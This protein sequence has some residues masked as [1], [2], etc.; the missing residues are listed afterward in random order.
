MLEQRVGLAL[1]P[2]GDV[3][4]GRAAVRRVV[5]EAAVAGRVVRRRDDDAVGRARPAALCVRMAC[6]I[7]GVGVAPP[8]GVD[9][10]VDAVARRGPRRSSPRGL[11]ERVR[12]AAEEQRPVDALLGAVAADRVADRDDVGL[13]ERAVERGA[14]MARRAE[15]DGRA[16]RAAGRPRAA[17]RR[18]RGRP[19][20]AAARRAGGCSRANSTAW[21]R[22]RDVRPDERILVAGEAL[23]DLVPRGRRHAL[24]VPRRRPLH[25]R[26]GARPPRPSRGL[27]RPAEHRPL[28]G[29]DGGDARRRRRGAGRRGADGRPDDAGARRGRRGGRARRTASTPRGRPRRGCGRRPRRRG[30]APRGDARA[31]AGADGLRGRGA[32]RAPG[33][34]GAGHGR[35]EH[36][37]RCDRRRGRVPRPARPRPRAERRRQ[38]L[39]RG[40]RLARAGRDAAGARARRSA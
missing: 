23:V 35:P 27:R 31:R 14:A 5:L 9:D 33:G 34:A 39:R 8:S 15:R 28:R 20:R 4:V 22:V 37:A 26:P 13:G 19:A 24:P 11:G 18:P 10:D 21:S 12:V 3:G 30:G 40:P 29:A 38:G 7:T 2:A 6:E 1:D 25:H 36:P 16:G 32:G 17:R